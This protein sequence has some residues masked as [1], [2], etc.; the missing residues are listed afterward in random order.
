MVIL[1]GLSDL[2]AEVM[3]KEEIDKG[4]SLFYS[5][6]KWKPKMRPENRLVWIHCWGIP[7]AAWEIGYIRKIVAAMGDLV[8]VDD[9]VEEMR[10]LDRARVL[11]RTP[12][13]PVIYHSVPVHIGDENHTVYLVEEIA[14]REGMYALS[15]EHNQVI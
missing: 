6:E 14:N 11:I 15:P 3:I 13:K 4:S 8:D 10:R 7:L 1:L 12:W 2:K 5:L 9:D